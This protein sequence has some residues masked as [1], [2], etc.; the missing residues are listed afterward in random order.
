MKEIIKCLECKKE[1]EVRTSEILRGFGK[2]CS[3]S[4]S[5]KHTHRI[6]KEKR[7]NN[8]KCSYCN[9]EFY[10]SESSK[11][12]S[13]SGLFFCNRSCKDN[14]Q[15]LGGLKEIQPPHYNTG[16]HNYRSIAY[17]KYRRICNRC[18]YKDHPEILQVHHKDRNRNNNK[19]ENLEILCPNCHQIEHKLC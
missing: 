4:C 14:A 19:V 18:G 10:K 2:F 3:M 8:C 17:R 6:K 13:K 1:K 5:A 7:I 15:R 11:K 9:I 12:Q 16:V